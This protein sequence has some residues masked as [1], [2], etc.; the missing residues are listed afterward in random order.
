MKRE[1]N[2]DY[3]ASADVVIRMFADGE[4]H[5]MK[6]EKLGIEFEILE[7]EFDGNELRMKSKREVPVNAS[8]VAAKFMPETAEVVNDERWRISDKSGSVVVDTKGV[9]IDMRSTAYMRDDGDNCIIHYDWEVKANIPIGSG[10]LE[11]FVIGDMDQREAEE[12]E[13][14]LALLD[15]Y[16]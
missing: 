11:K 2:A 8:G 12:K 5:R 6:M 15:S 7:Q 4:F 10:A 13:V 1:V 9:P 16:R 14:A 3:P